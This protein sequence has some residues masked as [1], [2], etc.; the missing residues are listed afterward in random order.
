M[1]ANCYVGKHTVVIA[2]IMMLGL[3]PQ[4]YYAFIVVILMIHIL[5]LVVMSVS[6]FLVLEIVVL[7][8]SVRVMM[9]SPIS[10]GLSDQCSLFDL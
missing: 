6:M 5:E 1:V 10:E 4:K 3:A 9:S 8:L 2:L 7:F